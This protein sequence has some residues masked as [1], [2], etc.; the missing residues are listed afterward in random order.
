MRGGPE[1]WSSPC[2]ITDQI[3]G[4]YARA[5]APKATAAARG[6][7]R[8]GTRA[9][10]ATSGT[11]ATTFTAAAATSTPSRARTPET[12]SAAS[13]SA[14]QNASLCPS[15][16]LHSTTGW[17]ASSAASRGR[18]RAASAMHPSSPAAARTRSANTAPPG[19]NGRVAATTSAHAP[20]NSG[21]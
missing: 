10:A 1:P 5:S 2:A 7:R 21:P 15:A 11:I 8:I 3:S 14:S 19:P 6:R 12:W 13:T 9:S 16:A 4:A 20:V 18:V 17:Y